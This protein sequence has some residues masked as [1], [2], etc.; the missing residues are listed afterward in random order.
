[1][2]AQVFG[3]DEQDDQPV[4][5]ARWVRLAEQVLAAEGVRRTSEL[6]LLFVD[7]RTMAELNERHMGASGPT[8][9]LAFPIDDDGLEVGR[10]PDNGTSG[11]DRPPV[12]DDDIPVLLGDVVVCPAVAARQAPEHA[13]GPHHRGTVDDEVALL[14][15]H[16]ILHVLGMD[17]A[18][19]E[20]TAE[21]QAKEQALLA[22][23]H[24]E[25]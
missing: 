22:R 12:D 2:S 20:E 3:V 24:P 8:D 7:E 4:D 25:P 23:F 10:W 9:V 15:V 17:H 13:G 18:E 14:V 19:P 21:M 1:M 6:S 11:P 5:V 16:G